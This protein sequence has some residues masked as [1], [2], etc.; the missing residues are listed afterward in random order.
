M[1]V[2]SPQLYLTSLS[3]GFLAP[4]ASLPFLP[5]PHGLPNFTQQFDVHITYLRRMCSTIDPYFHTLN[6]NSRSFPSLHF[7][8]HLWIPG[9]N[10]QL[11]KLL[12]L[13]NRLMVIRFL[14]IYAN[15][16]LLLQHPLKYL[17]VHKVKM[18]YNL[19]SWKKAAQ[20][21]PDSSYSSFSYL[22]ALPSALQKSIDNDNSTVTSPIS[23]LKFW[24]SSSF[25]Q[26]HF[27]M[28]LCTQ[29]RGR[30]H[31]SL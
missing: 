8:L 15:R 20:S 16:Q 4:F 13:R 18:Y 24:H 7:Y 19:G 1:L 31:N 3:P 30:L 27:Q 14:H 6:I 9:S 28:Q 25:P 5:F 11:C 23:V 17:I 10:Q 26:P 29:A 21:I 22:E 2:H 12:C